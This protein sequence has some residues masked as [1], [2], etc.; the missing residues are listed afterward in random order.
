MIDSMRPH[1]STTTKSTM[2]L[3]PIAAPQHRRSLFAGQWPDGY[4]LEDPMF[5]DAE[6]DEFGCEVAMVLRL[7]SQL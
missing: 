5:L 3:A 1:L 7:A 2:R 4:P 6:F